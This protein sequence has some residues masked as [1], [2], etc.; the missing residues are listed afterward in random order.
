VEWNSRINLVAKAPEETLWQR[1]VMDCWQLLPLL[2]PGPMAD[3]GSGG[4]LPGIILAIGRDDAV[5]L[6]E[7]DKRKAAFLWEA[8]RVLGLT[9]VHVHS[10][11]FEAVAIPDLALVTAR[12]LAPLREL[13]PHA[14]KL[15][16][17]TGIA[18]FPKGRNAEVELTAAAP[19]WF[20]QVERFASRTDSE[21]TIFRLSEIRPAIA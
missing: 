2:P 21:A 4:G 9:N 3:L 18:V 20:M 15:L 8:S 12:A 5:H 13:L 6:I 19:H 7:S 10:Q 17:P 1:H 14:A 16:G 11:R